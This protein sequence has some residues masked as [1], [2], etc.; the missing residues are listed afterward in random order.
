MSV[1]Y[2]F[3]RYFYKQKEPAIEILSFTHPKNLYDFRSSSEHKVILIKSEP[4]LYSLLIVY[5]TTTL[6]LQKVHREFIHMN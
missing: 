1:C 3:S 6:T 2:K 5:V 4:V